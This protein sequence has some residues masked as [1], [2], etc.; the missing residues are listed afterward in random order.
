MFVSH[1]Q[2]KTGSIHV[3]EFQVNITK[4][5]L[6]GS[7]LVV[8]PTGMGKTVIALGVIAEVMHRD[9]EARILFLAPTKPLV[10]QHAQSLRR[11]LV[12]GNP[13]V[14]TGDIEPAKREVEWKK[15]QLVVSTPQVVSNDL[16]ARRMDI[17]E[18]SLVIFDEA[19]RAVGDYPYV[20][21]GERY[22]SGKGLRL[23]MTASPGSESSKII[24][25]MENLRL[26]RT[27]I[28]SELDPDVA[29]YVHDIK[30]KWIRVLIPPKF[31]E[32]LDLLRGELNKQVGLLRRY[33][34]P[35]PTKWVNTKDLLALGRNIQ[36]KHKSGHA[37]S[38]VFQAMSAQ[39][40]TLK[41]NHALELLETQGAEALQMYLERLMDGAHLKGSSKASRTI[42][43]NRQVQAAYE[44]TRDLEMEHPK[45]PR[46]IRIV[47]SQLL[48]KP[49]S[50]I[51]VFTHYRD[52]A[53][54]VTTRLEQLDEAKPVRFVGQASKGRDSGM[55][56]N[57]QAKVLDSFRNGDYNVLIATSVAEEGLDIPS[58]DL[59]VFYEPVPS[60]I[61]TIQR[62]GR[63]GRERTGEVIVL[64]TKGTRDEGYYWSSHHK[65][66]KMKNELAMLKKRIAMDLPINRTSSRQVALQENN[67]LPGIKK[68]TDTNIASEM[69]ADTEIE[70]TP[71]IED[72]TEI[73]PDIGA[74]QTK[75]SSY[76]K[77][78]P[79]ESRRLAGAEQE[80]YQET[81]LE[82]DPEIDP[83]IEQKDELL[84]IAVDHREFSSGVARE[85]ARMNVKITPMQLKVADY[86]LSERIGVE[87]K[88]VSDFLSSMMDGRLF[89]Q[90]RA[91]KQ[92]Y[93]SPIL[94]LEGEGLYTTRNI[95]RFSI[96][97]SLASIVS[98]YGV[99]IL[100]TSSPEDTAYLLMGMAKRER[101]V[102]RNVG[103]RTGRAGT[104][105]REQQRFIIEGLPNVSAVNARRLLEHFGTVRKVMAADMDDLLKVRGIGAKTAQAILNILEREYMP[106]S[107]GK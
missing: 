48:K 9:P 84:T 28:R 53:S 75:L 88:E 65:E 47:R 25:V 41:L 101:S 54:V 79:P 4:S 92:A 24:E 72:E 100:R 50:R 66:K 2:I 56:Q 80:T 16:M 33:G 44:L 30:V 67:A 52:T 62:R 86:V 10:D 69:E 91:L 74:G 64:M 58:T 68:E 14:F 34:F 83:E 11:F 71:E 87:R 40:V 93:L 19:H 43:S 42:A 90:V 51:I 77:V 37:T 73:A 38:S 22:D 32:V 59:V 82:T 78:H 39:A 26:E 27:E 61:R 107:K 15:H 6:T 3:R 89:K 18:F 57:M 81:D 94:I 55:S 85:L 7:T 17:N 35:L 104:S 70:I 63:T 20:F 102:G 46:V 12:N 49:G 99:T 45:V 60:E 29:P 21:I 98:D 1:P 5:A 106:R 76:E 96:D 103:I 97:G 13:V 95:N 36:A 31:Q 23:G 8:L 105:T